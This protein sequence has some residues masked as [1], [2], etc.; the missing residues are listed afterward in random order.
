[1]A[2]SSLRA[3]TDAAVI[4]RYQY[5]KTMAIK[6]HK[7]IEKLE[8][9]P[10]L[11]E[12]QK[13]RVLKRRE[14]WTNAVKTMA[15]LK[16]VAFIKSVPRQPSGRWITELSKIREPIYLTHNPFKIGL[17]ITYHNKIRWDGSRSAAAF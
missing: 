17:N 16:N 12:T 8:E 2:H 14:A 10:Q 15:M 1:M 3:A 11:S 5:L 7:D 4:K 6:A 9:F 13:K